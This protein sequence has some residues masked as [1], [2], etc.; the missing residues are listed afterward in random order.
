ME[1]IWAEGVFEIFLGIVGFK[2][3]DFG[4]ELGLNHGVK[5]L[6]NLTNFGFIFHE[7][8]PSETSMIIHKWQKPASPRNIF[9]SWGTHHCE[10]KQMDEKAYT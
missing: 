2:D 5:V 10:L 9:N 3:L 4:I 6:E 7:K 8:H 1:K